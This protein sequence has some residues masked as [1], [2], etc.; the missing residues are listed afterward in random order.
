MDLQFY[1]NTI[2]GFID[3]DSFIISW[4]SKSLKYENDELEPDWTCPSCTFMNPGES[5]TCGMC[6]TANPNS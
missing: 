2:K 6:G 3:D 5:K 4:N 1:L